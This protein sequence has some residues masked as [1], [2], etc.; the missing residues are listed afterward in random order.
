MTS[1]MSIE[2]VSKEENSAPLDLI[3]TYIAPE[4]PLC[5]GRLDM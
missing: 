4:H 2:G 1:G 3:Y 5:Q